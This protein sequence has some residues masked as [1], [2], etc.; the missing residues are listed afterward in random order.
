MTAL[1]PQT[2]GFPIGSEL[3]AESEE[4]NPSVNPAPGAVDQE[5]CVAK[6]PKS[7]Y[8]DLEEGPG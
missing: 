7:I 3:W 6:Q 4:T 1:V 8:L 2:A 5:V